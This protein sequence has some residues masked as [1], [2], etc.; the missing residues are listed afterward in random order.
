MHLS[1]LSQMSYDEINDEIETLEWRIREYPKSY[2]TVL[3]KE[4]L[5]KLLEEIKQRACN[6]ESND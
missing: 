1:D 4:D 2:S 5:A 3:D 6:G